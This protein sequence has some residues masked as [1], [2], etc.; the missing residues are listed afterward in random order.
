MKSYHWLKL[1]HETLDDPK[2]GQLPDR[3]WRRAI[4][5]FLVAGKQDQDGVLPPLFD[6]GWQLRISEQDLLADLEALAKVG[7]VHNDSNGTWIVFPVGRFK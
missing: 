7:I 1:W 6:I 3:I 4:E 2:M 5:L